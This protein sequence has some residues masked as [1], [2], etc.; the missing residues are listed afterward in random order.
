MLW[1]VFSVP[2]LPILMSNRPGVHQQPNANQGGFDGVL[3]VTKSGVYGLIIVGNGTY[4]Y[5]KL[6]VTIE[7]PRDEFVSSIVPFNSCGFISQSQ[8]TCP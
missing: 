1:A 3:L 7:S 4:E 5:Q 2:E 8:G 6:N